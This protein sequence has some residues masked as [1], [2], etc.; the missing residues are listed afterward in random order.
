MAKLTCQN[1]LDTSCSIALTFSSTGR[2]NNWRCRGLNSGPHTCK[3]CALPLSYI[4]C[5]LVQKKDI[6]LPNVFLTTLDLTSGYIQVGVTRNLSHHMK[7]SQP[8]QRHLVF[9]QA[10]A[11]HSGFSSNRISL[12]PFTK[13]FRGEERWWVQHIF[14]RLCL[15][16]SPNIMLKAKILASPLWFL[17]LL[18]KLS[19]IKL[20]SHRLEHFIR[21]EQT[22]SPDSSRKTSSCSSKKWSSFII[23]HLDLSK[24][25]RG[26]PP[27]PL[28]IH[29]LM[30]T[31]GF[32]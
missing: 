7:R 18:Q 21:K 23:L 14:D 4:P 2:E 30:K 32:R 31:G 26:R 15:K 24:I 1:V 5:K 22:L 6:F 28:R 13:D 3:A 17:R 29:L 11:R 9:S 12:S 20:T 25:S 16:Q 19:A 8:C 10:G 27:H